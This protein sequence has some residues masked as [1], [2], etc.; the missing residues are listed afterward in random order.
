MSDSEIQLPCFL[1]CNLGWI[2]SKEETEGGR[3]RG[4]QKGIFVRKGHNWERSWVGEGNGGKDEQSTKIHMYEN[5][6]TK[7]IILYA[8]K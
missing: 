7:P 4:R 1:M 2:G 6:I 5:V 8:K 3:E